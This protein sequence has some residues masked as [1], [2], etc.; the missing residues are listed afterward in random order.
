MIKLTKLPEPNDLVINK[1]NLLNEYIQNKTSVWRKD[2]ITSAL[3]NSSNQKCA[4]CECKLIEESKYLEVEHFKHKDKH[5]N[6]V[7]NWDNLLPSCKKC[8]TSK[9]THDVTIIPIIDP[10][11]IDPKDHLNFSEYRL[12]SRTKLGKDTIDVLNLNDTMRLVT[13]RF[14]IGEVIKNTLEICTENLELY[15]NSPST[16]TKNKII[17]TIKNLLIECSP[18]AQYSAISATV[19]LNQDEYTEIKNQLIT[20]NF[21]DQ[22]LIDAEA[23]ATSIKLNKV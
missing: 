17:K 23:I 16:R 7:V 18:N 2:Y 11:V 15:N 13:K 1:T 8:N 6:D 20:L 12:K 5:P 14:N 9:G 3:L 22:D 4:Y 21:W 19:L 10:F